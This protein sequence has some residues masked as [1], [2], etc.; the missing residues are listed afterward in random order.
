MTTQAEMHRLLKPIAERHDDLFVWKRSLLIKP[1]HHFLRYVLLDNTSSDHSFI[2]WW[3]V[4]ECFTTSDHQHIGYTIGLEKPT[5]ELRRLNVPESVQSVIDGIEKRALPA[6][7]AMSRFDD[8]MAFIEGP[9]FP[10]RPYGGYMDCNTAL[11]EIGGGHLSK[12]RPRLEA[13]AAAAKI[14]R[15]S[16]MDAHISPVID[17][18]K[19]LVEANDRKGIGALL[20]QWEERWIRKN[21][22]EKHW[23]P[24]PFPV[25]L[26]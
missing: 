12:A 1:V 9:L 23:E 8:P 22:L 10:L 21:K 24:T 18:L 14:W 4:N 16:Y 11:M 19:P 13:M 7:R 20:G 17:D 25:E 15:G 2:S 26:G 3:G 6:L 5:G